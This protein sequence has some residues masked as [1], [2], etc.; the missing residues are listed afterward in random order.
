MAKQKKEATGQQVRAAEQ[1]FNDA[2]KTAKQLKAKSREAKRKVK[3][4]KKAAKK[5]SK[6]ARAA[7]KASEK[8]RRV[9]RRVLARA[10]KRRKKAAKAR[11]AIVTPKKRA[12]DDGD[13]PERVGHRPRR[14]HRRAWD[15]GERSD[16]AR[17]TS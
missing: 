12:S 7:R 10:A 1:A 11:Q 17:V 8:A 9:Y 5:A 14:G 2:A 16:A 13:S 15:I 4:A 3:E 6:D